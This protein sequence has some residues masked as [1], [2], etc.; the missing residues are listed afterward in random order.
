MGFFEFIGGAQT[1]NRDI[2]NNP[3]LKGSWKQLRQV[4]D[5][6]ESTKSK[7]ER[8]G[9]TKILRS[10]C[11]EL[12]DVELR[13]FA[14]VVNDAGYVSAGSLIQAMINERMTKH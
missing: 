7:T 9:Y 10:K 5:V 4:C 11:E 13:N 12:D 1:S 3:K 8:T 14:M 2:K 6:L